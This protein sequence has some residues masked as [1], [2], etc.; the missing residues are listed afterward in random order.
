MP[1]KSTKSKG[2]QGDDFDDVIVQAELLNA[3]IPTR[4]NTSSSGSINSRS[5]NSRSR[6][7]TTNN[8][9]SNSD[10]SMPSEEELVQ[11]CKSGDLARLCRYLQRHFLVIG[12]CC[13][14][15]PAIRDN[16]DVVGYVIKD[17]GVDVNETDKYGNPPVLV[18]ALY[19][20]LALVRYVAKEFGGDV[21][22]AG[23]NG[24]TPLSVAAQK[25]QLVVVKCLV[26][27][28]GTDIHQTMYAGST[29][30]NRHVGSR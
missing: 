19:G 6:K 12:S 9:N 13:L 21:D 4:T 15:I 7:N 14:C 24:Y 1:D 23:E 3:S 29:L 8:A 10:H 16:L 22:K 25:G 2:V 11:K 17:Y 28:L 5:S 18:A 27:K 20:Q 26:N 30:L